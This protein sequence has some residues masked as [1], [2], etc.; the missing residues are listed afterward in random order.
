MKS[1]HD[2]TIPHLNLPTGLIVDHTDR[3][4]LWDPVQSAYAYSYDTSS[5]EFTAYDSSYPVNYL[6]FNGRWGDDKL[7]GQPEI[8]GESKYMAGPNGP[9]FKELVR[10][11]VCPETPCIVLPFRTWVEAGH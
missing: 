3:G 5:Q 8:F 11:S 1:S 2:H 6:E 10:S 7:P 9:K 4:T